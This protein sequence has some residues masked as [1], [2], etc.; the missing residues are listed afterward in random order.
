V[1]ILTSSQDFTLPEM[2]GGFRVQVA[3]FFR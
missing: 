2:L 1:R 3:E